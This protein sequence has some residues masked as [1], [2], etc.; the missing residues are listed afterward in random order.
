MIFY[1]RTTEENWLKIQKEG[2]LWGIG[3]SYRYTYLSPDDMGESYG[4]VLL[5]VDYIPC[6]SPN[7]NYGF[8][9]PEGQYCWQF[10]VF[11]PIDIKFVKRI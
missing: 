3:R 7:D 1:H 10:S 8:D 9:P 6:G 5:L 2:I 4:D 11:I